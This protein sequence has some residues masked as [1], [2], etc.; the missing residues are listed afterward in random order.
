MSDL[1]VVEERLTRVLSRAA[2]LAV[3]DR[4]VGTPVFPIHAQSEVSSAPPAKQR[5][6][7]RVLALSSL[8]AGLVVIGVVAALV[9]PGS[10][11]LVPRTQLTAAQAQQLVC[12]A[13]L[14]PRGSAASI[15]SGGA[16]RLN[17]APSG[18]FGGLAG[19]GAAS[20]KSEP[21]SLWI[22]ARQAQFQSAQQGQILPVSKLGTRAKGV[23]YVSADGATYRFV[24]QGRVG[25]LKVTSHQ[26]DTVT[27]TAAS[28]ARYHLNL[29]SL[30][31]TEG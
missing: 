16:N 15:T 25:E 7:R 18:T 8:V 20:P 2:E 26:G 31:L 9:V 30:E 5:H 17:G 21:T 1:S 12:G 24:T 6:R 19:Q 27:L 11:T 22:F 4:P 23:L 28:G 10:S 3:P 29:T 14:C 13:A